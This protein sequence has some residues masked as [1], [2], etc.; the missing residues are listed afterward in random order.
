MPVA[1]NVCFR[2]LVGRL[3]KGLVHV[4]DHA[5]RLQHTALFRR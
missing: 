3:P 4:P 1:L 2:L 5:N